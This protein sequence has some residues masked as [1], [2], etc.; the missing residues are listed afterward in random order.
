ML[1]ET[2]RYSYLKQQNKMVIS[3]SYIY[4][5]F[6]GSFMGNVYELY[7]GSRWRSLEGAGRFGTL[8]NPKA[9]VKQ[10]G[11]RYFLRVKGFS[12]TIEVERL[13]TELEEKL[14]LVFAAVRHLQMIQTEL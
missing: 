9:V 14:Q 12:K 1:N 3:D 7:D 2:F 5:T 6:E 10:R 8:L 13:N 4:G 11:K